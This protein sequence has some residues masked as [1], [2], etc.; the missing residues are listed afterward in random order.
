MK[1]T[2]GICAGLAALFVSAQAGAYSTWE[3]LDKEL[4]WSGN[5]ITLRSESASFPPGAWRSALNTA[6]IRA[7]QNPGDFRFAIVHDDTAV[8]MNN[9]QNEVWFDNDPA[10]LDGNPAI[11]YNWYDCIDYW[12]FGKTVRLV[13]SDIIF[14][15]G[16]N[17][18][19]S[20]SKSGLTPYGG[21]G[22]P[23]QTTA[24]H[25]LGHA[26]G[27][28]H[29]NDTYNI[30]GQDWDHIHANGDVARAYLGEDA[31]N[32]V[33]HLYGYHSN[34]GE[35]LAV[36]HW[37]YTGSSGEYSTH[38]RT[39]LLSA[40]GVELASVMVGGEPVYLVNPG[41]TVQLELTYENNGRSTQST[42]VGFYL[43]SNSFISTADTLLGTNVYTLAR[44][45]V[46]TTTQTLSIPVG[47]TRGADYWLGAVLDRY[48]TLSEVAEV[49]NASYVPIRVRS[50]LERDPLRVL[51]I[52]P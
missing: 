9:G 16:V 4:R 35:D 43:S 42:D 45:V 2:L 15:S 49:N 3:C 51:P 46:W 1:T 7:N 24:L 39:R 20:M 18:E 34:A 41:Q 36:T 5:S 6:I 25:E 52:L 22:R 38:G 10:I 17:Y 48:N 19:T 27:L 12:I 47:V 30:M 28:A 44:N 33:V 29:T 23:F 50:L 31:G 13:E 32:G 40:S 26:M 37:R 8:A 21:T 11:T 14:D